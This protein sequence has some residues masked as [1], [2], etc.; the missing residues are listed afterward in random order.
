MTLGPSQGFATARKAVGARIRVRLLDGRSFEAFQEVAVGAVGGAEHAEHAALAR[1]KY[2][3]NGGDARVADRVLCLDE[4][5][6]VQT[7]DLVTTVL[8]DVGH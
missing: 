6:A 3:G 4:L 5:T 2:V 1:R 7:T 8:R